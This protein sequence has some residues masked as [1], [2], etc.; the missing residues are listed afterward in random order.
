MQCPTKIEKRTTVL[1][2]AVPCVLQDDISSSSSEHSILLS[3]T[4]Y[5]L[6]RCPGCHLAV[7][8]SYITTGIS[9]GHV[10]FAFE[11]RLTVIVH[12]TEVTV[13]AADLTRHDKTLQRRVL[14]S[15]SWEENRWRKS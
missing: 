8:S 15:K 14:A 7:L 11:A 5:R 6:Q 1:F 13:L 12:A 4:K 3:W 2:Q 10:S 9:R